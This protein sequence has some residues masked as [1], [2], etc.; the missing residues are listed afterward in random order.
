[1]ATYYGYALKNA[2]SQINWA[3]V[4]KDM[5]NMLSEE[6][7]IREEKKAAIDEASRQFGKTLAEAPQGENQGLNGMTLSFAND[8]SQMMF[9]Q[10]K[11]LKGGMLSVKDYTIARQNLTDGTSRLFDLS[12]E[13]Q[14]VYKEK[15]DGLNSGDLSITDGDIM[16]MIEGF[17]SLQNTKLYINPTNGVVSAGKMKRMTVDGK[18]V[19]VMDNNPNNFNSINELSNFM[20]QKIVKYKADVALENQ[21]KITGGYIDAFIKEP[22]VQ[23][24]GSVTSISDPTLR[25]SFDE[26]LKGIVTGQL[27]NE[28]NALST[29]RDWVNINPKTG[30]QYSVSFDKSQ[31]GGDVIY[32][33]KNGQGGWKP[34]L[35]AEQR[36]VAEEYIKNKYIN[37]L[38]REVKKQ[39]IGEISQ[40]TAATIGLQDR[41]TRSNMLGKWVGLLVSGTPAEKRTA[42]AALN[43]L[44][45]AE[46]TRI[47]KETD[48]DDQGN[49][50]FINAD[51]RKD[52]FNI[53]GVGKEKAGMQ[54]FTMYGSPFGLDERTFRNQMMNS[55]SK[56]VV[57]LK[58]GE[59]VRTRAGTGTT[60]TTNTGTAT[61]TGTAAGDALFSTQPK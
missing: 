43:A 52:P 34:V 2:D 11:L 14:S 16:A 60:T 40:T 8:A 33:E 37:M 55:G 10:D 1:M 44:T 7:R 46:G 25:K 30:N 48:V 3:E 41:T 24:A 53:T 22:G 21:V 31:Q 9:M 56:D 5:T 36:T 27:S 35:T 61:G 26:Y 42:S 58:K 19:D 18:E 15:M 23:R 32:L 59:S 57:L 50:F 51:G 38:D 49:V 39:S 20:K 45:N 17:G 28:F 29:L 47:G 12:K 6:N 54:M 4:G 13:W